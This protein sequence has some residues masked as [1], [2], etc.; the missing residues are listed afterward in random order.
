LARNIQNL[1]AQDVIPRDFL[2]IRWF[3][4]PKRAFF[5]GSWGWGEAITVFS[6]LSS[7]QAGLKRLCAFLAN[8]GPVI[9]VVF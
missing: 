9:K 1:V 5:L 7:S 2:Q 3:P 4:A 6:P 8:H